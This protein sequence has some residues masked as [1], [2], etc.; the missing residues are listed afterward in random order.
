MSICWAEDAPPTD[1]R[2]ITFIAASH[3]APKVG[4][5]PRGDEGIYNDSRTLIPIGP[6][7]FGPYRYCETLGEAQKCFNDDK[8]ARAA[9]EEAMRELREKERLEKLAARAKLVP[10]AV[11]ACVQGT[12]F[13]GVN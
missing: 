6:I 3:L 1:L 8:V 12:V 9:H 11:P 4:P 13:H 7:G 2:G 5:V 10:A